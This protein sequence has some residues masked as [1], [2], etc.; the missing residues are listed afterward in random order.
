MV[1]SMIPIVTGIGHEVDVT[2]ADLVADYHAHTPTEAAAVATAHWRN[3]PETLETAQSR[4]RRGV[5][6]ILVD[7]KN[8]LASI[9]RHE[10]FRRPLHRIHSLEQ[11]LDER[12]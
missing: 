11:F 4:L 5:R 7:A 2:I 3:V 10:T 1:A 6:A 8:Q 12:Q 9:A